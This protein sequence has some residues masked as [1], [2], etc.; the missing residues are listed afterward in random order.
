MAESQSSTSSCSDKDSLKS[1]EKNL[2]EMAC[3][4][5]H[6]GSNAD[7]AFVDNEDFEQH[8]SSEEYHGADAYPEDA[9]DY[10]SRTILHEE[11]KCDTEA[12]QPK[13]IKNIMLALKEGK[14]R[15]HSSPMRGCKAKVGGTGANKAKTE[16]PPKVLKPSSPTPTSKSNAQT[17]PPTSAKVGFDS[18]KQI[19]GMHTL[20]HQVS[21][22]NPHIVTSTCI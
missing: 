20:K 18:T 13:T 11:K 2:Q 5:D 12:K 3:S 19:Q 22:L 8:Y 10:N 16:A 21:V 9:E 1:S 15:E 17:P 6:K 4:D 7:V 14:T